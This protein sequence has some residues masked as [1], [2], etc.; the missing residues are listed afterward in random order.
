MDGV[1]RGHESAVFIEVT[2][3]RGDARHVGAVLALKVTEVLH[4]QVPVHI[5]EAEGDLGADVQV[6]GVQPRI[7]SRRVELVQ[8]AGDLILVQQVVAGDGH[9]VVLRVLGDGVVISRAVERLMLDV[10]TGIDDGDSHAR[11]G[12]AVAPRDAG[13]G[14]TGGDLH[15]GIVSADAHHVRG[16]PGGHH[17]VLNA[18]HGLDLLDLAVSHVGGNDVGDQRQVVHHVQ[19][20]A[21][22]QCLLGDGLRHVLLRHQKLLAVAHGGGVFADVVLSGIHCDGRCRFQHDGDTDDLIIR[23][24]RRLGFLG[25]GRLTGPR[26][27]SAVVHLLP[28]HAAGLRLRRKRD[29]DGANQ[30]DQTQQQGQQASCSLFV[31]TVLLLLLKFSPASGRP[32]V[33]NSRIHSVNTKNSAL[34]C[35]LLAL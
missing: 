12:V 22:I 19:L 24:Q 17:H 32:A 31:H 34:F 25:H 5:V 13:A 9:A 7:H 8:L 10:K 3:G 14:H 15:L 27:D 4:I 11:A 35:A 2:V 26:R 18:L 30:H 6:V 33:R 20:F 28:G 29:R 16:V 23:V 21:G 1:Q